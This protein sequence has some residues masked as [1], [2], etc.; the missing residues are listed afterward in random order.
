MHWNGGRNT[1]PVGSDDDYTGRDAQQ[2]REHG[3]PWKSRRR[4][5][6]EVGRANGFVG[7]TGSDGGFHLVEPAARFLAAMMRRRWD[8]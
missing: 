6:V 5:A 3:Y 1:G 4:E 8:R 2:G 7:N